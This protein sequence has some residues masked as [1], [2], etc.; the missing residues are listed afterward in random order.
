MTRDF[1]FHERLEWS[2]GKRREST[3]DTIKAMLDG[4]VEVR[5]STRAEEKVGVDFVATLRGGAM[6]LID[7][8][9]RDQG[10]K[11]NWRHDQPELALEVWSVVPDDSHK[12]V[13]GWTLSESKQTDL[14]L[15]TFAEIEECYLLPFQHL[16]MAFRRNLASWRSFCSSKDQC[17]EGR[18]YSR[19]VFVPVDLVIDAI[20]EVSR[21][22]AHD[23]GAQGGL[24]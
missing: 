1:D 16:R 21:R 2:K 17:T 7:E 3:P 23:D 15:F 9:R 12:G 24:L 10:A 6:V 13:A 22:L 11:R 19:A 18:Y 4:C 14:V 5:E 20:V 8:K